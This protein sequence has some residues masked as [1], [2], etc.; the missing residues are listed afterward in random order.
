MG[1]TYVSDI[2]RAAVLTGLNGAEHRSWTCHSQQCPGQLES[3]C[4]EGCQLHRQG[5][6]TRS[7]WSG[8]SLSSSLQRCALAV[9]YMCLS[10]STWTRLGGPQSTCM[11]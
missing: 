2:Y 3:I 4:V 7:F 5:F 11:P 6:A 1:H 10:A 9:S 8:S